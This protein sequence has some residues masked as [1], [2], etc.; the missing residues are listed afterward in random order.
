MLPQRASGVS[1]TQSS[2]G[3]FSS[4]R[5]NNK[6]RLCLTDC[7]SFLL[8]AFFLYFC[9]LL[10]VSICLSVSLCLSHSLFISR[11]LSYSLCLSLS[12]SAPVCLPLFPFARS[13]Y[14]FV[15]GYLIGFFFVFFIPFS[16]SKLVFSSICLT[17][18]LI[19]PFGYVTFS[20]HHF[21]CVLCLCQS[22][23]GCLSLDLSGGST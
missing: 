20:P 3:S 21:C 2:S 12:V 22:I 5:G 11:C 7:R 13:R 9:W 17:G 6:S 4:P 16:L 15:A 10:S 14:L 19:V 23:S 18:V 8:S 1:P